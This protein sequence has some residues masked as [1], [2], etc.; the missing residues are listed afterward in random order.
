MSDL[1]KFESYDELKE[2]S[3]DG[4]QIVIIQMK[5]GS[6]FYLKD[7]SLLSK[8]SDSPDVDSFMFFYEGQEIADAGVSLALDAG[9][10]QTVASV[11]APS[12]PAVVPP[13]P[14]EADSLPM[15]FGAIAGAISSIGTPAL[16]NIAKS[17]LQNKIKKGGSESQ[18]EQPTDCKTHQIRS[19]L[20]FQGLSSR[21]TA[22]ENKPSVPELP[23][24]LEE[25]EERIES[26]EKIVKSKK[27]QTKSKK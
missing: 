1:V 25:L 27:Q 26:L 6:K 23:V 13:K 8:Y 14:P 18:D 2:P 12:L 4:S 3:K 7:Q 9:Q 15:I 11:E 17:L 20:R 5:D 24:D 16:M 19:N 10:I 22:L 21:V